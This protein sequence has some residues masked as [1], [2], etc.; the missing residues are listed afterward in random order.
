[1]LQIYVNL[2]DF[3]GWILV[4]IYDGIISIIKHN[5]KVPKFKNT[6]DHKLTSTGTVDT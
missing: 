1:M 5:A 3:D 4:I 2:M 6:I